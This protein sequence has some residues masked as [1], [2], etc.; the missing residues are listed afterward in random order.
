MN[1]CLFFTYP[2]S[3]MDKKNL[4]KNRLDEVFCGFLRLN[5]A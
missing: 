1:A 4:S 5:L 3:I 2:Q